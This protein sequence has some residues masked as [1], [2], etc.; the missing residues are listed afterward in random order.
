VIPTRDLGIII[1]R[2]R[3]CIWFERES[4]DSFGK[5][6]MNAGV[7]KFCI[8]KYPLQRTMLM[9]RNRLRMEYPLVAPQLCI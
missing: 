5:H 4:L 1:L 9:D 7:L 2:T 3:S 6:M 8:F